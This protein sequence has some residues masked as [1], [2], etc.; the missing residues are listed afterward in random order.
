M[1]R[2]MFPEEFTEIGKLLLQEYGLYN[3]KIILHKKF[4]GFDAYTSLAFTEYEDKTIN[5][6]LD[7]IKD[8]D[9][10]LCLSCIRHEIAH[11]IHFTEIRK[12]NYIRQETAKIHG[13]E[14]REFA[15]NCNV[16]KEDL[17]PYSRDR[18]TI[19]KKLHYL[20]IMK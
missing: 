7:A 17:H 3:W 15:F 10:Q 5:I 9:Y 16:L 19:I 20:A 11:A 2:T 8:Y 1:N 6:S 4:E 18:N 13:K 14:W 12:E